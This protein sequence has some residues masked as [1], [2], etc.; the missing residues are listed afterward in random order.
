MVVRDHTA[1]RKTSIGQPYAASGGSA[2]DWRR[3]AAC[4]DPAVDPNLFFRHGTGKPSRAWAHSAKQVCGR[5]PV[6]KFC[7]QVALQA[8]ERVGVWGGKTPSERRRVALEKQDASGAPGRTPPTL[9]KQL[10]LSNAQWARIEPLLP[11]AKPSRGGQWRPHRQVIEAIAWKYHTGASWRA[12][13][14]AYGSWSGVAKRHHRW[15]ADGTWDRL[16]QELLT[17]AD[18]TD[19]LRW[20]HLAVGCGTS[21]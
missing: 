19:D 8:P 17:R 5:C 15:L 13:P 1:Q 6:A 12:L 2:S 10:L 18:P 9:E 4:A 7:L 14:A 16:K 3:W 11:A 20:L 21:E